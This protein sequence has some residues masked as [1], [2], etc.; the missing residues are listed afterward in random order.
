ML[1]VFLSLGLFLVLPATAQE[2][3]ADTTGA[4]SV[5]E[6][7]QNQEL[8]ELDLATLMVPLTSD[9]LAQI[10]DAWQSYVRATLEE[11]A[12]LNV[13]LNHASKSDAKP[14][15]DKLAALTRASRKLRDSYALVLATWGRKG[16]DAEALKEHKDYVLAVQAAAVQTADPLSLLRETGNWLVSSDGGLGVLLKLAGL[17]VAVWGMFFV[18]RMVRKF[19]ARGLERVP[20]LSRLLKTFVLGAV[21]WLTFALGVMIVLALFGVNITPLFAVLGGA[22]FILG[23]ALQETLGNLASG[24][25]IMVLKPFDTGDYIQVA[26]TSGV[27]D[28]MSVISTTIRTFDNQV[29]TVPN[30]KIWGDVI[31]NV[32]ASATRRVDLVFG[33]GYGDDASHAIEVLTDLV[34]ADG[35]CLKDPIAEVFVGEL[36]DSSVNIFCRPWVKSDDY[37]TVYWGLTGKAKERFDAEGISIPFPQRDVHLYQSGADGS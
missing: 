30:S 4:Q 9:E 19:A 35:L 2:T 27:V 5:F 18:S 15:R 12:H 14:L 8:S 36:G 34:K 24:L 33:I 22:S 23:F 7:A 16:A 13:A 20:N 3:G 29:I 21:Y 31:T 37:W 26:G 10:A 1:G 28:D 17:V 25:M 6:A 32:S 11:N